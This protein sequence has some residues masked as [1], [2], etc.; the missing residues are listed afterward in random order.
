M[1][2]S[3]MRS[4]VHSFRRLVMPSFRP[5]APAPLPSVVRPAGVAPA[6]SPKPFA[7][8]A[9]A[10]A[11]RGRS[12]LLAGVAALLLVATAPAAWGAAGGDH[13]H[14]PGH[15]SVPRSGCA[16]TSLLFC[17]DFD[18]LAP[19]TAQSSAWGTVA[20]NGTLTVEPVA[21][22][23]N[24]LHIGTQGNGSAFLQVDNF[25]APGNSFWGRVRLRV[26]AF[27]TAPDWA[28]WTIVEATGDGAGYIRPL[29]GQYVPDAG[30][31]LW[32]VGSDGG[33]T[34]DWTA[35]QRSV[36]AQAGAWQCVEWQMDA[37][38][39]RISVWIDGEPKSD[40][41]VDTTHH[42]GNPVDFV[43]PTFHTVKLGWQLYQGNPTPAGYDVR[44]DDI[45]L[46]SE[47][48]GCGDG[49]TSGR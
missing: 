34:G 42:G 24:D 22:G 21:S 48:V 38:D 17:E 37:T 14:R 27:P 2:P 20:N 3:F 41:T 18:A 11:A 8:W 26:G 25:T 1:S 23:G 15:P 44:L 33:P 46:S 47:R 45:A 39:N 35:W 10:S 36:P 6:R 19:G 13:T 31:D 30:T 28:H 9:E 29:G 43:F 7:A 32:G 12:P 49:T 16:G 40:L 5:A 4:V